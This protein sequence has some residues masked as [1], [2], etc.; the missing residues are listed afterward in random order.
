MMPAVPMIAR[1]LDEDMEIGKNLIPI[2]PYFQLKNLESNGT[3][4]LLPQGLT[5]VISPFSAQRD[6]R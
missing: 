2:F 5:V 4:V 1:V 3:K 6:F